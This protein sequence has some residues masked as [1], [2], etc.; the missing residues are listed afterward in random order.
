[1]AI[2]H[3][4]MGAAFVVLGFML[5][6]ISIIGVILLMMWLQPDI[7][8]SPSERGA[9]TGSRLVARV[10]ISDVS[11]FVGDFASAFGAKP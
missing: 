10:Q 11:L 1:M 2:K 4:G 7:E 5:G 9:L 6:L 8:H 3:A